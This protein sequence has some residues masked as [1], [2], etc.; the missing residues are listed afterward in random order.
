MGSGRSAVRGGEAGSGREVDT[1]VELKVGKRRGKEAIVINAVAF[2]DQFLAAFRHIKNVVDRGSD[3]DLVSRIARAARLRWRVSQASATTSRAPTESRC[4]R[5]S[6]SAL[7]SSDG[8]RHPRGGTA[9]D[10]ESGSAR[11]PPPRSSL[12]HPSNSSNAGRSVCSG[13][14]RTSAGGNGFLNDDLTILLREEA[15]PVEEAA[16]STSSRYA[17][18]DHLRLMF[19]PTA[20]GRTLGYQALPAESGNTRPRSALRQRPRQH[21]TG[22]VV[23]N[24]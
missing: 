5:A 14:S 6:F 9:L 22:D 23:P 20:G 1:T 12:D 8:D 17:M 16:S 18:T 4:G 24:A 10:V 19:S 15:L 2:A 7:T 21:R 3:P 11:G 13:A